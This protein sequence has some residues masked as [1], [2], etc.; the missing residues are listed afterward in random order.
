MGDDAPRVSPDGK[1]VAFVRD[2]K[3][4]RV[5]DLAAKT[6]RSLATGFLSRADRGVA[7]SP[8]S[9][10]VAYLGLSARSFRNVYA[11]PAAGGESRAV[12]AMPN[13]NTNNISWSPDGTFILF[14]TSQR[15][16]E[17][18]VVRVD[19]DPAD[20]EVPR[21]PLPRSVQGRPSRPRAGR[22]GAAPDRDAEPPRDPSKPVEI[23]FDDIRRRLSLLPVGV[24]VA[25]QTISPDGRS[26]C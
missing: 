4:L 1:S 23:V 24:D 17:G 13:A 20:A 8:D 22:G 5:L 3:D 19:L 7:W 2:G 10:W 16:E 18:Q 25:A 21:G 26:L 6:E 15:T 9:K 11:V 14:N 12:S